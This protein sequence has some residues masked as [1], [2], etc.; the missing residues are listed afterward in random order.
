VV[1]LAP[2][3]RTAQQSGQRSVDAARSWCT[4]DVGAIPGA[5]M[6]RFTPTTVAAPKSSKVTNRR[7]HRIREGETATESRA[8]RGIRRPKSSAA[9]DMVI[10][11]A[12]EESPRLKSL[13]DSSTGRNQFVTNVTPSITTNRAPLAY[14][15]GQP[16]LSRP[17]LLGRG[18][19]CCQ[20]KSEIGASHSMVSQIGA[21]VSSARSSA[22]TFE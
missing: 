12:L 1:A 21:A 18:S 2:S 13:M 4:T 5:F 20:S 22:S 6:P 15:P 16:L 14:G 9:S 7:V 10:L 19:V 11:L 8:K 17:A 3:G